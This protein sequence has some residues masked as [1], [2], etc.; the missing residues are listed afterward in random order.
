[1]FREGEDF[2]SNRTTLETG[3]VQTAAGLLDVTEVGNFGDGVLEREYT[4]LHTQ[5]RYR[6]TDRLT[7]AGNYTLSKLE[8]NIDGETSG[9]GPVPASPLGQ[10]EYQDNAWAFPIGDLNADQR[11]KIRA[12][13]VYDLL[14]TEYHSLNVSLLQNFFSGTPYGAFGGIDTRSFVTNPGYA[15][16]PANVTYYFTDR[17]AFRTD[18]ITRTDIALNYAFRWNAFGK[19]MEVFLQPEILNVFNEDGVES[20]NTSIFTEDNTTGSAC[21]GA[22]CQLFNPF[23]QTPVEGVHWSKG[24]NFGQAVNEDDFQDPR[25]FRFSIGFR[26]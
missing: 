22:A 16:P 8:G 24:V 23:T 13:A 11:H 7:L 3:T 15:V 6:L 10:P 19:S 2:Y 14:D 20:P 12:W 9:S 5:F 4:G 25:T 18:D 17:D 1:V 21:G 26:F